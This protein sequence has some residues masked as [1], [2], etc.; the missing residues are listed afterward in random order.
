MRLILLLLAILFVIGYS[1]VVTL[2]TQITSRI[3]AIRADDNSD[4]KQTI[5]ILTYSPFLKYLQNRGKTYTDIN[6]NVTIQIDAIDDESN[7]MNKM[8]SELN[9]HES[10]SYDGYLYPSIWM[11]NFSKNLQD[12]TSFV[13]DDTLLNWNDILNFFRITSSYDTKLLGVPISGD[14]IVLYYRSDLLQKYGITPP[15][16][17]EEFVNAAQKVHLSLNSFDNHSRVYGSCTSKEQSIFYAVAASY[18]QGQGSTQGIF[19]DSKDLKPL[20][21]NEGFKESLRIFQV[22][23][24]YGPKKDSSRKK[25]RRMFLNGNCGF[26]LD[27]PI[28]GKILTAYNKYPISGKWGVVR[29]PGSQIIYDR[30]NGKLSKCDD[31]IC[32][33]HENGVNYAP[34]SPTGGWL[35]GVDG[36]ISDTDQ[37]AI[38]RFWSYLSQEHESNVDVTLQYLGVGPFRITHFYPQPWMKSGWTQS[39]ALS[40]YLNALL[41]G[42]SSQN[43]A[44]PFRLPKVQVFM[45][46]GV[47]ANLQLFLDRDRKLEDAV[48]NIEDIWMDEI[49]SLNG[50]SAVLKLWRSCLGIASPTVIRNRNERYSYSNSTNQFLMRILLPILAACIL[51]CGGLGVGFLVLRRR[52]QRE[53]YYALQQAKKEQSWWINYEKI[54]ILERIGSGRLGQVHRG[55]YRGTEVAVKKLKG[56][57][58]DREVDKFTAEIERLCELRHPNLVLFMGACTDPPNVCLVSEFLTRGTLYDII[59]NQ[60]I[61][62]D[63]NM[64]KDM[65]Q[66]TVRGMEFLHSSNPPLLHLNIKSL[67]LLVDQ[68]WNVKVSDFGLSSIDE[69][70]LSTG[71]S[72]LGS[73]LWTSP[74]ILRRGKPSTKSDVYSFAIIL[75]ELLTWR[76]PYEG[77]NPL[78]IALAVVSGF[79]PAVPG[80]WPPQLQKLVEACWH[81][82]LDLRPSFHDL[83]S[84]L[85]PLEYILRVKEDPSSTSGRYVEILSV[86]QQ[87]NNPNDNVDDNKNDEQVHDA[88]LR[89]QSFGGSNRSNSQTATTSQPI[90]QP[91]NEARKPSLQNQPPVIPK[92]GEEVTIIFTDIYEYDALWADVPEEMR[93]AVQLHNRIIRGLLRKLGGYEVKTDSDSFMIAFSSP[94]PAII[95]TINLQHQLM[96]AEWPRAILQHPITRQFRDEATGAIIFR[97]LR[98]RIGVHCGTAEVVPRPDSLNVDFAGRTVEIAARV[99]GKGYYGEILV[100]PEVYDAVRDHLPRLNTTAKDVAPLKFRN[101]ARPVY[102]IIPASLAARSVYQLIDSTPHDA[103]NLR[104]DCSVTPPPPDL[105]PSQMPAASQHHQANTSSSM[106]GNHWHVAWDELNDLQLQRDVGYAEEFKGEWIRNGNYSPKTVVV[107]RFHK[108][109]AGGVAFQSELKKE[110]VLMAALKHPNVLE[111]IGTHIYPPNQ[112]LIWEYY[113]HQPLADLLR[114]PKHLSYQHR[115]DIVRSIAQGMDYLHSQRPPIIHGDL[116]SRAVLVGEIKNHTEVYQ[117]KISDFGLLRLKS[118]NAVKTQAGVVAWTSPERIVGEAPS[119]ASDVYSFGM[120]MWEVWSR[121][122]PYRGMDPLTISQ[123]VLGEYRPSFLGPCPVPYSNLAKSCWARLPSVRPS[124]ERICA[125]LLSVE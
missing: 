98:V 116:T 80:D 90:A 16:T 32:Q 5:K 89:D 33:F 77:D 55:V 58:S 10:S 47:D 8:D 61:L 53:V 106:V 82:D 93:D 75:W 91:M 104:N 67:N 96:I 14:L 79:R 43:V 48:L 39:E 78:H 122:M 29:A 4:L 15:T 6:T 42:L 121:Q 7:Y 113:P 19:F 63:W 107:K 101:P 60:N 56:A 88:N 99:A 28:M 57:I 109:D 69:Q 59:H 72:H 1:K 120:I 62:L 11:G 31:D 21:N 102:R 25:L 2:S 17:W 23:S 71:D 119:T 97:G 115:L 83:T 40:P 68:S 49:S 94:L 100:T 76:D 81:Q 24:S 12:L 27:G 70:L 50:S 44:Y 9:E 51:F 125:V 105:N 84:I 87:M 34:F 74:E 111:L 37:A 66:D 52:H 92:N 124:F 38:Y 118:F 108:Q 123:G 18:L 110:C 95:F 85:A 22:M 65:A 3:P 41:T 36:R 64:V 54:E 13:K 114:S 117:V 26:L 30:T 86:D 73:L 46:N 103:Q 45:E 35:G 20:V 112:S